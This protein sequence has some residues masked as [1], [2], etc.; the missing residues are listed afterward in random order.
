[1]RVRQ[2]HTSLSVEPVYSLLTVL[3]SRE[4]DYSQTGKVLLPELWGRF[5][6]FF[7]E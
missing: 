5:Q 2:I 7:C 4:C 3:G 6:W 1:M